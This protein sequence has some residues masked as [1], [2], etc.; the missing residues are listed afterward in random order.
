MEE[1]VG[2]AGALTG[3]HGIRDSTYSALGARVEVK[4]GKEK[5]GQGG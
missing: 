5:A 2:G 3:Q 1:K 4:F